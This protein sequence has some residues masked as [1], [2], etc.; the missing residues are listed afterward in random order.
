MLWHFYRKLMSIVFCK[1]YKLTSEIPEKMC[2]HFSAKY[3]LAQ[4]SAVEV[5]GP[6]YSV[7]MV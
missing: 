1:F 7:P 3:L 5:L 6:I 2:K 4:A